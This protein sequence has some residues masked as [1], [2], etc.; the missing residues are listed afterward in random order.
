MS[1]SLLPLRSLAFRAWPALAAATIALAVGGRSSAQA[2][3]PSEPRYVN[4]CCQAGGPVA[5]NPSLSGS[6]RFAP[7]FETRDVPSGRQCRHDQTYYYP[8]AI[9]TDRTF[10]FNNVD[11][12]LTIYP[13]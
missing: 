10:S 11:G 12:E 6:L 7:C 9:R 1:T 3:L 8:L 2:D 5:D 13:R 4:F